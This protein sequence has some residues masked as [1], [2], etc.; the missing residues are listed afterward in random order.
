MKEWM[1]ETKKMGEVII[2][3]SAMMFGVY[4]LHIENFIMVGISL[5]VMIGVWFSMWIW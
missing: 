2:F 5:L 3:C 4:S 1:K